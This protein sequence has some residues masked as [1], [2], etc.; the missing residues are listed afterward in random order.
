MLPIKYFIEE[1]AAIKTFVCG[2]LYV[3]T[4]EEDEE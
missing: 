4:S 3:T 1:K 2:R